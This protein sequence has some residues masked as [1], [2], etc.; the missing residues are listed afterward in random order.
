MCHGKISLVYPLIELSTALSLL[1]LVYTTPIDYW[2]AYFMLFSALIVSIR[3]DME[4]MLLSRFV[5][6]GL[7]PFGFLFSY[8]GLLPL[9]LGQSALGCFSGFLFLFTIERIY[10]LIHKRIGL[11]QGDV[12]LLAGIGSFLGLLGWWITLLIASCLGT[13][14]GLSMIAIYQKPMKHLKIPFGPFLAIGAM[15]YVLLNTVFNNFY[16]IMLVNR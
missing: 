12:E 4:T 8:L 1:A 16:V 10:F 7:I 5:T 2:F 15:S 9:S 14:I 6:L 13:I 11:G 3:T